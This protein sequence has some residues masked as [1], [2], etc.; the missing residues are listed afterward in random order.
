M[1]ESSDLIVGIQNG[2]NTLQSK[3]SEFTKYSLFL[4]GTNAK[5]DVLSH[6]TPLQT[7]YARLFMVRKPL[8][9]DKTMKSSFN[10]FKHMLEYAFTSISGIGDISLE[11]GKISGSYGGKEIAVPTMTKEG[12]TSFKVEVQELSGSPVREVLTAWINGIHDINSNQT[13]Y[14]GYAKIPGVTTDNNC[15]DVNQANE[16]AE[17]IYVVTDR[18]CVNIEYACLLC[19][20]FPTGISRSHFDYKSGDH[21]VTTVSIEFACTLYESTQ[22]NKVANTLIRKNMVLSNSLNFHSG[23]SVAD[24]KPIEATNG[25]SVTAYTNRYID[26]EDGTIKDG[27]NNN[28]EKTMQDILRP[29]DNSYWIK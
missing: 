24:A 22:I 7:G 14:N 19:N 1:A 4:G 15:I 2:I 12:T 27:G 21:D 16:T 13:H 20:C 25:N 18:T 17:F 11:S 8:F 5:H 23:Y 26:I 9:M 10:K 6:Y 3:E 29:K 28:V